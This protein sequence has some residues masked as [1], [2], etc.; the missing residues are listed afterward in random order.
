[1]QATAARTGQLCHGV[2]KARQ[3]RRVHVY[4]GRKLTIGYRTPEQQDAHRRLPHPARY[5]HGTVV[6]ERPLLSLP[7]D[8]RPPFRDHVFVGPRRYFLRRAATDLVRRPYDSPRLPRWWSI[9]CLRA[10]FAY[11]S[12]VVSSTSPVSV[13]PIPNVIANVPTYMPRARPGEASASISERIAVSLTKGSASAKR[14]PSPTPIARCP[15]SARDASLEWRGI[16]RSL[17]RRGTEW[18]AQALPAVPVCSHTGDLPRDGELQPRLPPIADI[19]KTTSRKRESPPTA[20]APTQ[21]KHAG[22]VLDRESPPPKAGMRLLS[23]RRSSKR[24]PRHV[25]APTDSLG[26]PCDMQISSRHSFS[27]LARHMTASPKP[28]KRRKRNPPRKP[29]PAN[30][31]A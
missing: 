4:A 3:S 28:L 24:L 21:P 25:H 10:P 7:A 11:D 13:A 1:M 5:Q 29:T 23:R 22:F 18:N 30:R 14:E 16:S 9:S 6:E 2:G 31:S 26:A 15:A 12:P 27:C 20:T 19:P 17:L 8:S